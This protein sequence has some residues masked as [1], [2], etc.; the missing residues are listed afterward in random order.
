M[1]TLDW[2]DPQDG[3]H[4]ILSW[5]WRTHGRALPLAW[6]TVRKD[7]LADRQRAT[8]IALVKRVAGLWLRSCH[9]I[10]LADRGFGAQEIFEALDAWGWDWIIRVKGST[11]SEIRP[12]VWRPLLL[13]AKSRPVLRDLLSVRYGKSYGKQAY[14]LRMVVWAQKGYPDPWYVAVSA[15]LSATTWPA[16]WI[17]AA[18]GQRFTTEE[19]FRD[20]KNDWYEGFQLDGVKLGTPERW[21][22]L[23]WVFAWA[24]YGLNVGG[25]ARERLGKDREWRA[26]TVTTHRTHALWRLGSWGLVK[27]Q[28][29][30]RTLW[31]YQTDFR[32][33]IPALIPTRME[34]SMGDVIT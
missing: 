3:I 4:Q 23:L 32:R 14:R 16:P 10:L 7:R 12:G 2:T 13:W 29:V 34:R 19:C 18:Y 31:R 25:W 21:D 24:Y 17:T 1:I 30:W 15:G 9:P 20:E 28:L 33:K 5:N 11:P 27:G 22:R 8:E 26:N 6:V